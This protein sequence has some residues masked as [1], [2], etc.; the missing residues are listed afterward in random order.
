VLELARRIQWNLAARAASRRSNCKGPPGLPCAV[1]P[2]GTWP[3]YVPS[4]QGTIIAIL[5]TKVCPVQDSHREARKRT[6]VHHA[7]IGGY[8]AVLESTH[9][10][11]AHKINM[12]ALDI[13]L[14]WWG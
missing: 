14:A 11:V 9:A 3:P 10:S 13:L 12:S 4:N 5:K 1:T 2:Q 8:A 6:S 7:L